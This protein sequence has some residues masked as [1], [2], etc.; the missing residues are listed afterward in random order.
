MA[1]SLFLAKLLGS[2]LIIMFILLALRKD[3]M[4]EGIKAFL[5]NPAL[6]MLSGSI[7]ILSGLSILII[8]PIWGWQWPTVITVLG[9]LMVI[10]GVIR[11][12]Y[13]SV[14][15][16]CVSTLIARKKSWSWMMIIT[17]ILGLFLSVHGFF[18]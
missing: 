13:P 4:I 16:R 12:A 6:I 1:I 15:I 14:C 8:H 3:E 18:D 10:K 2:Y 9:L 11:F 5:A 17:L 7:N